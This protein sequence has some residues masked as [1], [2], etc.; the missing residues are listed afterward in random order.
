[1]KVIQLDRDSPAWP[2][3]ALRQN[4]QPPAS[5]FY[6]KLVPLALPLILLISAFYLI[7]V[8]QTGG[9]DRGQTRGR[10]T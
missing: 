9:L 10:K 3:P 6:V 8:G 7:Y 4:Y 5:N 2:G 1:M